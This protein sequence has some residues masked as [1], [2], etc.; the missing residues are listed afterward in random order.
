MSYSGR[1]LDRPGGS[2]V[3][4]D[5]TAQVLVEDSAPLLQ[6]PPCTGINIFT[7]Q[8]VTLLGL[9]DQEDVDRLVEDGALTEASSPLGVVP[10]PPV[11]PAAQGK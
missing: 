1:V 2:L 3:P 9:Y 6:C 10:G 7:G 11:K 4:M 8:P 5:G